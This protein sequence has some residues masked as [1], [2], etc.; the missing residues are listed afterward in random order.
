MKRDPAKLAAMFQKIERLTQNLVK[1]LTLMGELKQALIGEWM[2]DAEIYFDGDK[3]LALVDA[4]HKAKEDNHETFMFQG[5]EVLT[6]YAKHLID[7]LEPQF[8]ETRVPLLMKRR[9]HNER[10]S[11]KEK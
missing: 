9:K 8:P 3:F 2:K 1:K 4:Y 7:Y 6:A 10:M 5:G 11:T